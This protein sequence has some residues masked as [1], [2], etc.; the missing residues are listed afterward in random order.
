MECRG[1]PA[2]S[3]GVA[4]LELVVADGVLCRVAGGTETASV[5]PTECC[6]VSCFRR[7]AGP[8]SR[9]TGRR[10]RKARSD[11]PG[12]RSAAGR[13]GAR[14]LRDRRRG[15]P[16]SPVRRRRGPAILQLW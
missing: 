6:T 4:L 15:G 1:A 16:A 11:A 10:A 12:P 5:S 3:L 14:A 13:G 8:R 7:A 2:L 9:G